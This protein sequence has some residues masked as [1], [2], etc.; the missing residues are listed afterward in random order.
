MCAA[1]NVDQIDDDFLKF[2]WLNLWPEARVRLL[3][4]SPKTF[5]LFGAGASH[6]YN[7]N[8]FGVPVPLASGFFKAFHRL[9][10]SQGFQAHVGPLISFLEHY[11]G[12]SPHKVGEWDEN[13]EDFMTS[14]ENELEA[15]KE[16]IRGRELTGE[17]FGD[18]WS[19]ATVF[20]NMTF[21]FASVLNEAQNGSSMSLYRTILELCGP[22]DS[23]ATF[24]WDTLLD[25]ALM[26]TGGWN[27]N[28]GYGLTFRAVLDGSWKNSLEGEPKFLTNWTL[29]K[30]HGSTNWLVPHM[31]VDFN[32]LEYKSSV[33]E[34]DDVFLYWH[35]SFPYV[36]HKNRWTGGYVPTT[37]C[38]YPPNIPADFFTQPQLSAKPGHVFVKFT[39]RFLS[40]F[41][42]GDAEGVP[43][44]PIL[45]TPVRQK[46]Y[47][48]YRSS[49]Q[50]LWTQAIKSLEDASR[51]VIVGYSFP[52]TDTRALD[53]FRSCLA[54]R[55][56]EID[57]EIVSPGAA[58]IAK[59]IGADYL[60]KARSV[61]LHDM[62]LEEYVEVLSELMPSRMRQAVAEDTEVREWLERIYITSQRGT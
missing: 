13:I 48:T 41:E 11:R 55:G 42:E 24:N 4:K 12:V 17:E 35:S 43:S 22:N 53:L 51:I 6:H 60:D 2:A 8:L 56:K 33:P 59:R 57:I 34:S 27:P 54:V 44:S 3:H 46:K 32:T 31:G 15:M 61:K 45:I 49:I 23:F 52:P 16:A 62:K 30:L 58:D 39:P 21:I 50:H 18:A 14:I 28:T 38:Y 25:R 36:T 47:D 1:F 7:L 37:Y 19:Y 29:I 9:P 5:W 20:N 40:A 26:D 10:T